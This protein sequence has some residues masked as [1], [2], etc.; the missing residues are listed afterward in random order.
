MNT[1]IIDHAALRNVPFLSNL[2]DDLHCL[3]AAYGMIRSFYEPGW[4]IDW[5][6]W[7]RATG[8]VA[9][10][11][12]WS[13]AG[14]QWF[15]DNGYDVQHLTS[16]DYHRFANEGASY[17]YESMGEQAG[18]WEVEF[19]DIP[20]EQAR[21]R[22]FL[23]SG[24][25]QHRQ[26]TLADIKLFLDRGYLVKCIVNLKHLN[27]QPGFLG[28][29]VIIIGYSETDLVIH[30]PGLPARPYRPVSYEKFIQ[31]WA[32]PNAKMEKLDAILLKP[33]VR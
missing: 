25:W 8:F 23:Q 31:A 29:A 27:D 6:A 4:Q 32:D 9:G 28:H 12:S 10:K 22:T 33:S 30:D 21:C 20:L 16:F 24:M 19:T 5:E 14:L 15:H 2:P 17:L 7:S 13:F 26:P 3:Q 1:P 11:G 18:A